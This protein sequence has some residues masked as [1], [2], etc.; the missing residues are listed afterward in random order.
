MLIRKMTAHDHD[1]V[2]LV[3]EQAYH[4][5]PPETKEVLESKFRFGKEF[6]F[7]CQAE[8]KV[9]GYLLAHPW[10]GSSVP[11]LHTP[12]TELPEH[13]DS[14][15]LH[16]MAILPVL[17]GK[18]AGRKLF[19]AFKEAVR[20]S[21]F[22]KSHLTAVQA[23]ERFWEKMGYTIIPAGPQIDL[24]SYGSAYLMRLEIAD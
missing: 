19:A 8:E 7:V 14:I 10:S 6:C 13:S 21:G 1:A 11:P 3:Q 23:A 9:Q 5:I 22:R 12:L 15:Y 24:S 16:D 4:E 17:R 20:H 2:M 18:Q